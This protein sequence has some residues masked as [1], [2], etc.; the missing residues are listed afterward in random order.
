[1]PRKKKG[2]N[3]ERRI[4]VFLGGLDTMMMKLSAGGPKLLYAESVCSSGNQMFR[5]DDQFNLGHHMF[6]SSE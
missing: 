1:M 2:I 3:E 4:A 5:H 6:P